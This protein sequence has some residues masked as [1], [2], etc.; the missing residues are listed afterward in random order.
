MTDRFPF[1]IPRGWFFVAYSDELATGE[2]RTLNYFER[3]LVLFRRA[4]GVA[5]VVD[6]FCPHLGAH[7]GHGGTVVGNTLRCPFHGWRFGGDGACVEVPYATRI[8]ATARLKLWPTIERNGFVLVWYDPD[9]NVELATSLRDNY[10]IL[11]R[12]WTRP[13]ALGTYLVEL[14]V[15]KETAR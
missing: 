6:A 7:L 9:V 1:P 12:A 8:P 13:G 15:S 4:D 14:R 11:I 3:E 10:G 5:H 2:V